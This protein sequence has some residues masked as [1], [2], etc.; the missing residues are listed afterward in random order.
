MNSRF[1]VVEGPIGV[2]KTSLARK[3]AESLSADLILE[4]VSTNP[5]LERFYQEGRS[6]ALPAQMFFLFER[7]R[8]IESLR[9]SDLFS[10]VRVSDYIF[11][12]DNLFAELNLSPDELS[13]YNQV[14]TSLNIDVPVPDLVIYL[15]ASV[16]SLLQRIARRGIGYERAIERGYLEKLTDAYA[17]FFHAYNE[18]PL[19]IVNASQ[20]DLVNNQTDYDQLFERIEKTTGGRHFFNPVAAALA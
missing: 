8:Q 11:S 6:A 20:I 12:K 1:I 17:R 10:N 15:Q 14:V 16:D 7:A 2:G 4:E 3:L 19:L 5:F 9:Q 18:G 13:L